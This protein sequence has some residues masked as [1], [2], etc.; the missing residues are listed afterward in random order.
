[1]VGGFLFAI[2]FCMSD[3][4][5]QMGPAGRA[6]RGLYSSKSMFFQVFQGWLFDDYLSQ[7]VLVGY[8]E[9]HQF[10]GAATCTLG[11]RL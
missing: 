4:L 7:M 6:E 2:G 1:L 8:F 9:G 10:D 11:Q 5:Y 3:H